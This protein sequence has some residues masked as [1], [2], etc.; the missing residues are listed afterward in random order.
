LNWID[1]HKEI[2]AAVFAILTG[3][4]GYFY[5]ASKERRNNLRQALYLLLEIW[6]RMNVLSAKSPIEMIDMMVDRISHLFPKMIISDDELQAIKLHFPPILKKIL[7]DQVLSDVDRLYGAF[8]DV[9]RLIAQSHPIYAY[10]LEIA[11]TMKSRLGFLT[12][13]FAEAFKPLHQEGGQ[14]NAFASILTD[15]IMCHAE[16]DLAKEM[17]VGLRGL[18][19]RIGIVSFFEI[20]WLIRRR[21][22]EIDYKLKD[23]ID[24]YLMKISQE[25]EIRKFLFPSEPTATRGQRNQE[26]QANP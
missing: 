6:H 13:Y 22:K 11:S 25:P 18:S 26:Q 24:V 15:G 20:L 10:K 17:E 19:I 16:R 23:Q 9:V 7:R 5:R 14:S 8:V 2:A 12:Q 4:V 1:Q 21:H 3:V